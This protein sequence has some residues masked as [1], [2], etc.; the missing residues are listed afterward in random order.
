MLISNVNEA[1]T[2]LIQVAELAQKS[3]LLNLA[4]ARL[5]ADAIE[6]LQTPKPKVQ[7]NDDIPVHEPNFVSDMDIKPKDVEY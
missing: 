7:E 4:D 5:T 1:V 6:F 2:V 3:G